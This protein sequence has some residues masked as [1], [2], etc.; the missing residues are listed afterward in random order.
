[1]EIDMLS[2]KARSRS[3]AKNKTK[4]KAKIENDFDK[5]KYYIEAVQCPE[6]DAVFLKRVYEEISGKAP[7]VLRE[8][9]CGTFAIC[10]EWVKQNSNLSAIGVDLDPEPLDYGRKNY[11]TKLT[12]EQK[13]RLQIYQKNVLDPRLPKADI[14]A[15]L[16][17][18]YFIFKERS[19]LKSYFSSAYEGL[20]QNGMFVVDIFGGSENQQTH[21]EAHKNDG[22]TYFWNQEYFDPITYEAIF[23]IHFQ[24]KGEAK[25]EKV[26][27]YDWRMWTIPEIRQLL[28]EVGF[29]T[30]YVYWEGTEEDGSGDGCFSQTLKGEDCESWVAYIVAK[31]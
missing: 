25:R 18:S 5:Y 29:E 8:D 6:R 22:F 26:F 20:N 10:C 28:D 1:M 13:N 7:K 21:E 30:T 27:C 31:K 23:N 24:R 17:F 3:K 15:A 16:N 9:F 11:L 12:Q 2:Q 19:V 4:A 14:I